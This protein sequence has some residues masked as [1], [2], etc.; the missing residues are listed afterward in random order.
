VEIVSVAKRFSMVSV[1]I[2][3]RNKKNRQL[4]H[5]AESN[6]IFGGY[7]KPLKVTLIFNE[8]FLAAK[9]H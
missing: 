6:L 4:H 2:T 9:Y 3:T 1:K 8:L 7:V 5:T